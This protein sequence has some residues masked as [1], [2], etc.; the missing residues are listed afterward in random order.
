MLSR[1]PKLPPSPTPP[2]AIEALPES[3]PAMP[4]EPGTVESLG[5][6]TSAPCPS[7]KPC[8]LNVTLTLL[9]ARRV[10]LFVLARVASF[11]MSSPSV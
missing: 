8:P 2:L 4:P 3:T 11:Q 5:R 7:V 1:R 6:I 9:T 10:T